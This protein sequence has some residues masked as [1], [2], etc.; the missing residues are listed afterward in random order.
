MDVILECNNYNIDDVGYSRGNAT[1]QTDLNDYRRKNNCLSPRD[2]F[3]VDVNGNVVLC[4][5]I[6][7][8]LS[9][10]N[11]YL[12]GNVNTDQS[13]LEIYES[14]TYQKFMLECQLKSPPPF[15]I[16]QNCS[17]LDYLCND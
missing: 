14:P 12:L 10:Y 13:P 17:R 2:F 6:S 15:D 4:C 8:S 5:N 1:R 11:D 7:T 16:C 3:L 9:D